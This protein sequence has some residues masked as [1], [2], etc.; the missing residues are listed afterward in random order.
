MKIYGD[1]TYFDCSTKGV[2]VKDVVV[3]TNNNSDTINCSKNEMI[4]LDVQLCKKL[5]TLCCNDNRLSNLYLNDLENLEVVL[6]VHNPL[7]TLYSNDCKNLRILTCQS[8][9]IPAQRWD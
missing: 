7:T 8:A 4:C 3:L 1:L 2:K 9:D 5:K 6:V